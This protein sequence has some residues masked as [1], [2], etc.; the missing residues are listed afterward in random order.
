MIRTASKYF[1]VSTQVFIM[2]NVRRRKTGYGGAQAH[3][4]KKEKNDQPTF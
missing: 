4:K 3:T 2:T 1:V